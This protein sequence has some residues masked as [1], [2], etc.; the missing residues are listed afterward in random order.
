MLRLPTLYPITDQER[1]GLRHSEQVKLLA[2]G[3]ARLVQLRDKTSSPKHFHQ[4]AMR[5]MAI[6]RE[7]EMQVIINDRVDVA[8]AV[9]AN[10]VHLGQDDLS[11][12]VARGLLGNHAIIGISTHNLKQAVGALAEPVDYIAL[13]PIFETSSKRDTAPVLGLNELREVRRAIGDKPIVAIGG[14][15]L[16][17]AQE[18]L[19]AG[20]DSVAVIS[21]LYQNPSIISDQAAHFLA[22]S[23]QGL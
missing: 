8:L 13:G 18:T 7:F 12:S 14:I 6:A 2:A 1:S 17:N 5:V 19:A 4:E 22:L 3:G 15:T 9:S 16:A 20:A 23:K 11:P 10:G 21:A